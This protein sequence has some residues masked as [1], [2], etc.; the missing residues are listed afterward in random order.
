MLTDVNACAAEGRATA[1]AVLTLLSTIYLDHAW[2]NT[3]VVTALREKGFGVVSLSTCVT[4]L[5][6]C[7]PVFVP[8]VR[9]QPKNAAT[10]NIFSLATLAAQ[11]CDKEA[12]T[13]KRVG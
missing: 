8:Q 7:C 11:L 5:A 4:R 1:P 3:A 2:S 12:A 10:S 13:G 9:Y 6:L